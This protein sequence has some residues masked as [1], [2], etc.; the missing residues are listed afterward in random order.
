MS[1]YF[2]GPRALADPSCD[3]CDLYAFPSPE[4]TGHLVLVV[5][6]FPLAGLI[7]PFSDAVM[8]RFRR[9]PATIA[10]TGT[11]AA[12]AVGDTEAI[13]HCTFDVPAH[14][15]GA[16]VQEGHCTTPAGEDGVVVVNDENGTRR[17]GCGASSPDCAPTRSF[18]T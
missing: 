17:S 2:S 9:R 14:R 13:L 4:R 16:T 1:D 12:F 15:E 7:K 6:V 10:T 18:L 3:I 8:C 5:N 11:T